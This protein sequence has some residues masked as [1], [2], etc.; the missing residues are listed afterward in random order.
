MKAAIFSSGNLNSTL[1]IQCPTGNCTFDPIDTLG[2]CSTCK[3][4]TS[5]IDFVN[6]TKTDTNLN[7]HGDLSCNYSLPN[8]MIITANRIQTF[9]DY[10]GATAVA[11]P[12]GPGFTRTTNLS[13]VALQRFQNLYNNALEVDPSSSVVIA[14]Y[15][16]E[17]TKFLG[18]SNPLLAFGRLVFNGSDTPVPVIGESPGPQAT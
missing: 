10:G 12:N 8:D 3:D 17:T 6:C 9:D 4:V 11:D 13:A 1:S 16:P 7:V 5:L 14:K 2:F 18:V 15:S